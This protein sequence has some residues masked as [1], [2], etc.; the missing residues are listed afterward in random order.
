MADHF[1]AQQMIQ[2]V[3]RQMQSA[4]HERDNPVIG[5][6]KSLVNYIKEFEGEL[7]DNHEVGAN[8]VT[9]G[10]SIQIHVQKVSYAAP[11]LITFQGV[12][13]EGRVLQLIQHVSQLSFLLI[14]VKK[15]EDKPYRIGF[16]WGE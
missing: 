14:A 12:D 15:L 1:D 8:L 2:K 13:N 11:F 16:I 9:F 3:Q 6:F 10:Q 4:Q 7:D 5:V